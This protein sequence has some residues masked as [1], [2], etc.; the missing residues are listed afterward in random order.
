MGKDSLFTFPHFLF[1]SSLSIHFLNQKLSHFV[2][3]C[4]ICH[5]CRNV[6]KKAYH[7][8][9]EKIIL[10]RIRCEKAPQVVPACPEVQNRKESESGLRDSSHNTQILIN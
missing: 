9:Y 8:R 6:T 4:Q 2:A 3:K 7:T 5:F 1:I 10:G